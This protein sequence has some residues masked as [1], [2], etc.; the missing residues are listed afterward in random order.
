MAKT[1]KN[2]ITDVFNEAN[3]PW[4]VFGFAV[5]F[6]ITIRVYSEEKNEFKV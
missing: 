5:K 2:V 3:Y 6:V 1:K 4:Q